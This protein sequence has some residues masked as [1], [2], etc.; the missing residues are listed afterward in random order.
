MDV[1]IGTLTATV[2]TSASPEALSPE[3]LER[4]VALVIAALDERARRTAQASS[5]TRIGDDR[6]VREGTGQ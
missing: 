1:S 3:T 2:R 6:P 4:L 5:D